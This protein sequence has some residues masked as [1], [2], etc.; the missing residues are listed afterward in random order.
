MKKYKKTFLIVLSVFLLS[1][2]F[3]TTAQAGPT[4]PGTAETGGGGVATTRNM[5]VTAPSNANPSAHSTHTVSTPLF[6]SGIRTSMTVNT[7]TTNPTV[8]SLT[9]GTNSSMGRGQSVTS[10]TV[11]ASRR[12]NVT[13]TATFY[14]RRTGVSNWTRLSDMTRRL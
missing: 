13:F 14:L 2:S 9:V 10:R 12:T 6:L 11:T 1:G 8:V 5:T 3:A 7:A 4:Q